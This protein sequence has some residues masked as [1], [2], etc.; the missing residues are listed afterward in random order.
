[1]EI[2]DLLFSSSWET[3]HPSFLVY[4]HRQETQILFNCRLPVPL[5]PTLT[6]LLM[7]S[8][9]PMCREPNSS[10]DKN[11]WSHTDPWG[12]VLGS[13]C[14]RPPSDIT[15]AGLHHTQ[16]SLTSLPRVPS[17]LLQHCAACFGGLAALQLRSHVKI[18]KGNMVGTTLV[19]RWSWPSTMMW[20]ILCKDVSPQLCELAGTRT[21]AWISPWWP[22]LGLQSSGDS[23]WHP[24]GRRREPFVL[25]LHSFWFFQV[26]KKIKKFKM[27]V[28]T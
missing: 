11:I 1:M 16:E 10:P 7:C 8:W 14:P 26:Q 25:S 20:L 3:H 21:L 17:A 13:L 24:S 23:L 27:T 15:P 2:T 12:S 9:G 22:A 6:C 18:K 28:C 19:Q 4:P 5:L